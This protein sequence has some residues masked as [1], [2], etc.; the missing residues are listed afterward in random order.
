MTSVDT[1]ILIR[2]LTRDDEAQYKKAYQLFERETVFI[3]DTVLLEAEWVLRYAYGF[4]RG[5]IN[6]AL[7]GVL[8]LP[9][10]QTFRPDEV[11]EAL[12]WHREGLDFADALHLAVSGHCGTLATFDKAFVK[13]AKGRSSCAV[14]PA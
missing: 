9:N 10:V 4:D 12:Q 5:Q 2:L 3:P 6:E 1:H 7:S 11:Q 14:S 13:S 8:G